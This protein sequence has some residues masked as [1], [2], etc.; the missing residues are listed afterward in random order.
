[1]LGNSVNKIKT[2]VLMQLKDKI[3]L[4]FLHSKKTLI[5]T[6]VF[7]AI[8]F[9]VAVLFVYL[10][11][12]AALYLKIFNINNYIPGSVI[13]VMFSLMLVLSVFVCTVGLMN[14]LYFSKDN[15]ILLSLPVT[16][17]KI[18]LSKLIVFFVYE[19]KKNINFL[20]PLFFSYG[21]ISGFPIFYYL[22]VVVSFILISA[23]TVA[24]SA[25][26]SIPAMFLHNFLKRKLYIQLLLVVGIVSGLFW[27]II[28]LILLIPT[29]I[30]IIGAWG[31]IFW[32]IQDFLSEFI[33]I[34]SP[35]HSLTTMIIGKRIAGL[36]NIFFTTQ[37]LLTL[38]YLII[39]LIVIMIISILFVKPFFFKMASK[40][41]EYKISHNKKPK[42]NRQTHTMFASIKKEFL[43]IIRSP[44]NLIKTSLIFSVLP[45]AI[46]LLNNI[47]AAMNTR[48]IGQYMTF[49]FNLLIVLLIIT[50]HNVSVASVYSKE[51]TSTYLMK[52]SPGN[53]MVF[54]L[55]K[56][57][58]DVVLVIL[59]L[60]TTLAIVQYVNPMPFQN[61]ALF[62]VTAL[63]VYLTH[64]LMSAE[65]DIMNPQKQLYLTSG[66]SDSNPNEN[67][68]AILSFLF[69][70]LFFAVS[71]FLFFEGVLLGWF[72]IALIAIAFFIFRLYLFVNRV[73]IYSKEK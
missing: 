27:G 13:T 68:S 38:L 47:Y 39:F 36:V 33:V 49:S 12:Y 15:F 41:F 29:N 28:R 46:F 21:L 73:K 23:A 11:L 19:L 69:S 1:M 60:I 61:I 55:S 66:N 44:K 10:L 71:M 35:L 3:D 32:S 62:F 4:S 56:V 9:I 45:I 30:N 64:L 54:L 2:L 53:Q 67:K 72:K 5:S 65:L 25:L 20:I 42:P 58:V 24:L 37:G 48:L 16:T 40:P 31:S 63:F 18:F 34:F 57:F 50:S 52:T 7:S 22:W 59:S 14:K 8:K 70:A 6:I 51:G 43:L 17:N 26:L